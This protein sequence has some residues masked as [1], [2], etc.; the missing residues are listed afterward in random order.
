MLSQAQT[1]A[2]GILDEAREQAEKIVSDARREAQLIE[3]NSE[4]ALR[5]AARNVLL[6]LRSELEKRVCLAVENLLKDGLPAKDLAGIIGSLCSA[7]LKEHGEQDNVCRTRSV[8]EPEG[9]VKAAWQGFAEAMFA[10]SCEGSACQTGIQ[11]SDVLMF[12]RSLTA[13]SRPPQP[14][15]PASLPRPLMVFP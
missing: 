2:D 4:Q 9:A 6:G 3:Q 14:K 13:T 12:Q 5:Q 7:Y 15:S 11:G 8:A 1:E 10:C